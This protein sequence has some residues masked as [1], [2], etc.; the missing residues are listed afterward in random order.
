MA[1]I[2]T[3]KPLEEMF[4]AQVS[5]EPNSGCWLW[6][7]A[8]NYKGYGTIGN[9]DRRCGVTHF[10]LSMVGKPRPNKAMLACHHCDVPWCVNPAHLFWGTPADNM[11]DMMAKGRHRPTTSRGEMMHNSVMTEALVRSIRAEVAAGGVQKKI[12]E[13]HGVT[14]TCIF[15]IVHRKTWRHV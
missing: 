10:A 14:P 7:G 1:R 13:R 9:G 2:Y 6:E 5:P 11:A 12:A 15:E 4:W 8:L 3:R